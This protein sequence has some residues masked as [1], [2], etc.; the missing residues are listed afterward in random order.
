LTRSSTGPL[1]SASRTS[2]IPRGERASLDRYF[3][4]AGE[5]SHEI[6]KKAPILR[7]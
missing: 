4:A 7:T 5:E 2:R 3:A 6:R 1:D